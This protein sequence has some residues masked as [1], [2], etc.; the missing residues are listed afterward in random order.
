MLPFQKCLGTVFPGCPVLRASSRGPEALW[1]FLG[2]FINQGQALVN[3]EWAQV[4]MQLLRG[5]WFRTLWAQRVVFVSQVHHSH[6]CCRRWWAL[7]WAPWLSWSSSHSSP[8]QQ[9]GMCDRHFWEMSGMEGGGGWNHAEQ[10]GPRGVKGGVGGSCPAPHRY[11]A[12]E[13]HGWL[14]AL[15]GAGAGGECPPVPGKE[16]D[17]WW[18]LGRPHQWHICFLCTRGWPW[19]NQR[20]SVNSLFLLCLDRRRALCEEDTLLLE[21]ML[22]QLLRGLR[23][24]PVCAWTCSPIPRFKTV[25][26]SL[27]SPQGGHSGIA[28]V[29]PVSLNLRTLMCVMLTTGCRSRGL[30]LCS[31]PS[32]T[33]ESLPLPSEHLCYEFR[34]CSFTISND[35]HRL[36]L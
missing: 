6:S 12:G 10:L 22:W 24:G 33:W 30:G 29:F 34:I 5:P 13:R 28:A 14:C 8:S 32:D 9:F 31:P 2:W 19:E 23:R 11:S 16:Q 17:Q 27:A 15:G 4:G 35:I 36:P 1:A 3:A 18:L 7:G 21:Q 25:T 26:I 20:V